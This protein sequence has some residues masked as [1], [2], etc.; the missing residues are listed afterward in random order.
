[1][2]TRVEVL[3]RIKEL[4]TTDSKTS[5]DALTQSGQLQALFWVTN[6]TEEEVLSLFDVMEAGNTGE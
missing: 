2:K 5:I 1:M 4:V 3:D 6:P